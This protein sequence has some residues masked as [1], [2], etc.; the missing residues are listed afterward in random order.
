MNLNTPTTLLRQVAHPR[1]T[2]GRTMAVVSPV[3]VRPATLVLDL[4]VLDPLRGLLSSQARHL[5]GT[6]GHRPGTHLILT[7]ANMATLLRT[8]PPSAGLSSLTA[9][10]IPSSALTM[11]T[12]IRLTA[13][14]PFCGHTDYLKCW[15]LTTNPCHMLITKSSHRNKPGSMP[16]SRP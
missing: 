1:V 14:W 13:L 5:V 9:P 6:P 2:P 7:M 11:V 12:P 8:L 15:M 16:S 3:L 4:L 10:L